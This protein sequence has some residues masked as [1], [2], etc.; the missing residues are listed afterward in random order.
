LRNKFVF[1][2]VPVLVIVIVSVFRH[3]GIVTKFLEISRAL[4]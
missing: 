1:V 3:L 4:G 2:L